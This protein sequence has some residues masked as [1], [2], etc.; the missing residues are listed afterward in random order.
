MLKVLKKFFK[1]EDPT[2]KAEELFDKLD[3]K[4]PSPSEVIPMPKVKPPKVEKE[5]VLTI[6]YKNG[7]NRKFSIKYNE[8]SGR[9]KPWWPFYKW[10]FKENKTDL[11]VYSF[12][13]N[14]GY[15]AIY[16][17]EIREV[18]IEIVDKEQKNKF[19]GL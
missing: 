7:G 11:D 16:R 1:K 6:E 13:Y 9:L 17:K 12:K 18:Q 5:N 8:K 2:E 14:N 3:K 4:Y 10:L 19:T 15:V